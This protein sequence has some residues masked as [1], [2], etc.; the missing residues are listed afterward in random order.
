MLVRTHHVGARP[1]A[2]VTHQIVSRL[3]C[4]LLVTGFLFVSGCQTAPQESA[5]HTRAKELVAAALRIANTGDAVGALALC[6]QSVALN[7]GSAEAYF[8]RARLRQILHD[9]DGARSDLTA[10]LQ[11]KPDWTEALL[12]RGVLLLKL[13]ETQL[14]LT[15][16]QKAMGAGNG[17][18]VYA[19]RGHQRASLH[20]FEGAIADFMRAIELDPMNASLHEALANAYREKGDYTAAIASYTQVLN[21]DPNNNLAR[22]NRGFSRER[23]RDLAGSIEDYN[24]VIKHDKGWALAHVNRGVSRRLLRDMIGALEDFDRAI[25][26]DPNFALGYHNRALVLHLQGNRAEALSDYDR[27]ITLRPDYPD[28]RRFRAELKIETMDYRGALSDLDALVHLQPHDYEAYLRRG[29]V[30]GMLN[31]HA[32]AERDLSMVIRM[33]PEIPDGYYE[34]GTVRLNAGQ[35]ANAITD[36]DRSIAIQPHPLAYFRR[37]SAK[38]K[39]GQNREALTDLD[40][41]IQLDPSSPN[42][43]RVRAE[44]KAALGDVRGAIADYDVWLQSYP[45]APFYWARAELKMRIADYANAIADYT[46]AIEL[47]PL[48]AARLQSRGRAYSLSGNLRAALADYMRSTELEPEDFAARW[49]VARLHEDLGELPE[50]ITASHEIIRVHPQS[51]DGY[52][53]RGGLKLKSGDRAGA[54]PDFE[55]ALELGSR[56]STAIIGAAMLRMYRR[57]FATAADHLT[58]RLANNPTL[59][60]AYWMRGQMRLYLGEYVSAKADFEQVIAR[61]PTRGQSYEFRAILH[62]IL[63]DHEAALIDCES[64]IRMAQGPADYSRLLHVLLSRRLKRPDPDR[65]IRTAHAESAAWPRTLARFLIGEL[66]EAGLLAA[67]DPADRRQQC[68]VRYYLGMHALLQSNVESATKWFRECRETKASDIPEY[69][70]ASAELQD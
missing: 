53:L 24:E 21:L 40:T 29:Y 36:L 8:L 49:F 32:D 42:A 12:E 17:A 27:A 68:E 26:I 6:D 55:K 59:L 57:E 11:L 47:E 30:H 4:V 61:E 56:E 54:L 3:V 35:Y 9:D 20:D 48:N 44:V 52:D 10:A 5:N 25:V 63:G 41:A 45:Q 67:T 7:P 60:P 22:L 65:M 39:L 14:A 37:G 13:G 34:R 66:D 28:S 1:A 23:S 51:P 2:S 19:A 33:Q 15:D 58:R 43:R 18:T 31:Q 46:R 16:F 69:H 70:L 38:A 50:A 64:A 62:M